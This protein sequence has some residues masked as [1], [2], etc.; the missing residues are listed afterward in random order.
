M[1]VITIPNL[2]KYQ[3]YHK[4]RENNPWIKW[5][6]KCL[7]DEKFLKLNNSERWVFIGLIL[8][9]VEKNNQIPAE[10][11]IIS[12]LIS[13]PV[14]GFNKAMIKL[15]DL[16]L[17]AI[18]RVARRYQNDSTDKSRVDKIRIDKNRIEADTSLNKYLKE[19]KEKVINKFSV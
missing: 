9:A 5:H 4:E 13:N 15:L 16:K 18:K 10:F 12:H 2:N 6:K 7:R 19:E 17:I 14:R 8:L 3:H 11:P 1:K